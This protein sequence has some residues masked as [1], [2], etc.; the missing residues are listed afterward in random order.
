MLDLVILQACHSEE[1]GQVFAKL[2]ARH[3]I[4]INKARAVLEEAS[5]IFSRNLY[6]N[7]LRGSSVCAA[8]QGAREQTKTVLGS[9]KVHEVEEVFKLFK[10]D[11]YQSKNKQHICNQLIDQ[12]SAAGPLV[13]QSEHILLK[14]LP[15]TIQTV[16]HPEYRL[17]ERLQLV[18][19]LCRGDRFLFQRFLYGD[20]KE[21]I[22]KSCLKFVVE[23]KVFTGG[24]IYQNLENITTSQQLFTQLKQSLMIQTKWSESKFCCQPEHEEQLDFIKFLTRFFNQRAGYELPNPHQK[25]KRSQHEK[26]GRKFLLMLEN[27]EKIVRYDGEFFLNEFLVML[28]NECNNLT[29][30]ISS[31]EWIDFTPPFLP[32]FLD[33]FELDYVN[34]VKLFLDYLNLKEIKAQ[35]VYELIEAYPNVDLSRVLGQ[36]ADELNESEKKDLFS[37]NYLIK[38]PQKRLHVLAAHDLF[39]QLAG[40]PYSIKT[41][42]AFYRNP[43]VDDSSLKGIYERLIEL[44]KHIDGES[45]SIHERKAENRPIVRL[46]EVAT[47]RAEVKQ[48]SIEA[49]LKFLTEKSD[50]TQVSALSLFYFLGCFEAGICE[51]TLTSLMPSKQ[52]SDSL[53]LLKRMGTID[54]Q[55]SRLSLSRL[56]QKFVAATK[57]TSC[58]VSLMTALCAYYEREILAEIYDQS[59]PK[60]SL[61]D[62]L[63]AKED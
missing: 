30:V 57:F 35:E 27:V 9:E 4:C 3:V 43:F 55:A 24:V 54:S 15:N 8:F 22:A 6:Q 38:H 10:Y 58:E 29:I 41:I 11:D 1:V 18:K 45:D 36:Q 37:L 20:N 31:C 52:L 19:A 42:A 40:N 39:F 26:D 50:N 47:V 2:C 60:D 32:V 12:H 28:L 44:N 16:E 21:T 14:I 23:R 46:K 63:K 49:I 51:A 53:F 33:V 48:R 62:M 5:V 61:S 13:C 56:L 7:L 34:S 17:F 25:V 59:M